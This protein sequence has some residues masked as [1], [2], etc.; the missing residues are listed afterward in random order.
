MSGELP[1]GWAEAKLH[2]CVDVLDSRRI[3]VNSEERAKRQGNIPY[4]GATGQVGWIDDFIFDEELVLIGEDGAPFFD[5]AKPIAYIIQGKSW[6]NNHAH[7]LR[8]LTGITTNQYLKYYFDWFD[9]HDYVNGTTRLKLTQ[10]SMNEIPVRLAPINEQRRIV[11]KLEKFMEKVEA[12]RTRLE[13]IPAILKRFRQS[14]LTAACSGRL[15]ANWRKNITSKESVEAILEAI[16]HRR[17]TEAKSVAQKEKLREL[18]G[19]LEENDSNDLPDGWRFV[20]LSKLC[21]SFDYGTS[22]KSLPSGKVPVLRMGNIQ[23]G[24]I[25]WTNLVYTSDDNEI[26]K[27]FLRPKTVLFNRT[28]SPELVGKTAIYRG[29]RPAIFAGYLIR[30]NHH[31]ELDPEYL[32]FCLNM[33]YAKEFCLNVKTDGVSQSNINAQKLGTFE[34]PFC[35]LSE[36]HE[37]VRRVDKL[38]ALADQIEAR[39][40]KAKAQVDKLTQSILAKAFRGELVPQ[41]P[42]DEP[43]SELLNRI[44]AQKVEDRPRRVPTKRKKRKT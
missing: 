34:V 8:A 23:S 40:Q 7:V 36:Q 32:N 3:P 6:V 27:Y 42:N 28:N 2:K 19:I 20:T 16:R 11:S 41:D 17:E 12:S 5:K 22:A 37:I 15:T 14:V 1:E 18:Y 39:Y 38:F 33:N 4:Y 30:I 10:G 25:D 43:A 44:K 21:N 35:L 9:F 24:K 26:Q 13:K 31:P 29:E